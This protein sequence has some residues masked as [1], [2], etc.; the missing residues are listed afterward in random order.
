MKK[1]TNK[2]VVRLIDESKSSDP[3]EEI[4]R[5]ARNLVFHAL[6]LGWKGPPFN[7]LELSNILGYAVA[8]N[9]SV[10]DARIQST[11]KNRFAIE[12]NPFQ[13]PTRINF[14]IAHEIAHTLFSDC[15]EEIRNRE[16]FL[17]PQLRELEQLCNIGASEIQ[18]PYGVFSVDA[19]KIERI[20]LEAL[21]KLANDYKAS[22][23]SLLIRFVEVV[24]KPCAIMIAAFQ[25]PDELI[26]DY[27]KQSN[28]F[29][30]EIPK[31]FTIPKDSKAYECVKPG[32]SAREE[33]KWDFLDKKSQVFFIG[34]SPVRKDTK[35][36]VGIIIVHGIP[37]DGS[38][39]KIKMEFGDASKPRGSGKKII[40]QVV[41]TS[42]G[43]GLGFGKSLSKNYPQVKAAL[44][45]WHADKN[46][47]K[48]GTSQLV[49]I[50]NDLFVFQ[51][52]AQKGL[53]ERNDGIPL[54]Y[55]SLK[56]CLVDLRNE[57]LK[58]KA[59]IHMPLIGAGQARG[60]WEV[61]QGMIHDELA[62]KGVSVNI[63]LLPGKEPGLN[64]KSSLTLFPEESTWRKER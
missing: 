28:A 18:L 49:P 31:N 6:E 58:L 15:A 38:D 23:E 5:R 54:K 7:M 13:K 20:T 61:I 62:S 35:G 2:S 26:I 64:M 47:F 14:S 57:A 22:L 42:G 33:V 55:S 40:A 10:V 39:K 43:L 24:D 32:W 29:D 60:N 3:V 17:T 1:W 46:K 34:L 56:Q 9:E 52:L 59:S 4:R 53:F 27:S 12:Y 48:L 51:M 37:S 50:S 25:S 63:Y 8:P 30:F 21:I 36:R 11:L 41:N 19:N 45:A 16:D 44:D